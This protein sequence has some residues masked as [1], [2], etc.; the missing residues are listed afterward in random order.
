[1]QL[2]RDGVDDVA[3]HTD[4]RRH[5]GMVAYKVYRLADRLLHLIEAVKPAVEVDAA[6]TH[7]RDVA[8][9]NST[10]LH[11]P[12]HLAGVHALHPATRVADHKERPHRGVEGVGDHSAG[13]LDDLHVA[14][15]ES[16][17]SRE[18]LHETCVH[19]GDDGNLLVGVFRCEESLVFLITYKFPVVS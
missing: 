9:R 10:L 2:T 13:V 1:M 19:T 4:I 12:E 6:M 16:E 5:K 8:L 11:Q 7:E 14:V 3:R 17:S 15:T 18:Q